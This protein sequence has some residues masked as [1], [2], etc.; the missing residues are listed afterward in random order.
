MLSQV[1]L[2]HLSRG[3]SDLCTLESPRR[4]RQSGDRLVTS[5]TTCTSVGAMKVGTIEVVDIVVVTVVGATIVTT[6]L[7]TALE[8][9]E[10]A[11][12]TFEDS[13]KVV[14]LTPCDLS[15]SSMT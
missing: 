1:L 15:S 7:F 2:V 13:F 4:P 6:V 11:F 10:V 3:T 9:F 8:V 5:M 14:F 12:L